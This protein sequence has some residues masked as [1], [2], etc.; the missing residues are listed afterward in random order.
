MGTGKNRGG[1][2]PK[3]A[4]EK[5]SAEVK[6]HVTPEVK[7]RLQNEAKIAGTDPG[8]LLPG[9]GTYGATAAENPAGNISRRRRT[10]AAGKQPEPTRTHSQCPKG[11]GRHR[12]SPCYADRVLRT[13]GKRNTR[14][15]HGKREKAVRPYA[16]FNF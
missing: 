5:R 6:F 14:L 15:L 16:S 2:R 7:E 11:N 9:K 8:D 3:A 12:D 10:D 4:A 13:I 1:R